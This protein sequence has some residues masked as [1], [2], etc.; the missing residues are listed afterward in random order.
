MFE[1]RLNTS[2]L[3]PCLIERACAVSIVILALGTA[4]LLGAWG[5]SRLWRF[6]PPELSVRI[7]NPEIRLATDSKV[8]VTQEKPFAVQDKEFTVVQKQEARPDFSKIFP[9]N[10]SF[11]RNDATA[12]AQTK[13]GVIRQEVTVFSIVSH[14]AGEVVT[15]W[16]FRD[17]HGG[18]PFNQYCYYRFRNGSQG[19]N[20]QVNIAIDRKRLPTINDALVPE[21]DTALT[22]CRWSQS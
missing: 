5:I 21:L 2:L 11:D 13:V 1:Q 20:T 9:P 15:G 17:G 18:I 10:S 8:A 3:R 6:E 22:K 4:V 16:S 7:E 12:A 19:S 14:A